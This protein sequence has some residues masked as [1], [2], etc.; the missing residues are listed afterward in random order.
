MKGDSGYPLQPWLLTPIENAE[1]NSPEGRY[2]RQ[3]I[4]ARNV[5]E[6]CFGLLKQRFRYLLKQ[7]VLHYTPQ[8]AARICCLVLSYIT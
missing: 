7:R 5:I 2:T 1:P 3:H 4:L 8:R 6:R